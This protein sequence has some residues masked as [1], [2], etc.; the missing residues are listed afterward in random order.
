M[1]N[2]VVLKAIPDI[3][4]N[5]FLKKI[6]NVFSQIQPLFLIFFSFILSFFG[7]E[8]KLLKNIEHCSNNMNSSNIVRN[9]LY[10]WPT[11]FRIFRCPNWL[12]KS[13][14]VYIYLISGMFLGEFLIKKNTRRALSVKFRCIYFIITLC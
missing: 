4:L 8:K 6:N 9:N 12:M 13:T 11:W 2:F 1:K 10:S 3:T 7:G 5:F 14:G